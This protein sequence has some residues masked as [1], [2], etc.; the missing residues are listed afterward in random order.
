[1][2][3]A[4]LRFSPAPTGFLH[5]GSVRTALYNY[6]QARHMRGTF[7]LRIED[8]DVARSTQQST[9]Q[10]LDVL[11][12]LDMEYDE[13][14]ILQS[15]RF[16]D[17]LAAADRLL[18][19][20]HA[21]E[22]YCTSEEV[23]ARNEEAMK[24][25]RAPGYDGR[26]R[27]LT[28]DERAARVAEGRPRSVR[29][30]T[31]DEGR[32]SFTDLIRG[33]VSVE[34]TTISDF[35]IVRSNGTPVFFL[36]NAL[37]DID[38]GITHV[39]R[40]EDLIDSTHR[41]LAL[42]R[43]LGNNTPPVY[44]HMPLILGPGGGKLSKRH[45][46]VSVE[47]YRDAGYLA[48]ALINYL[49]LLG[50][51]PEDGREV[52]TRDELIAEFD[53]ERVNQS[54]AT[55]DPKKLEWMNGQ[56]IRALPL[57]DL[58]SEVLPFA[59][60]RY[61]ER[62]DIPRYEKGVALAQERAT[63]LVQIADQLEFLFTTDDDFTISDEHWEKLASTDHAAEILDLAIAHVEVSEWEHDAL[64]TITDQIRA[65]SFSMK[66]SMRVLYT[67][68]ENR[69]AGLPLFEAMLMLGRESSLRRLR[70]ARDRV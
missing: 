40:G 57:A 66:A 2:S 11:R 68:I 64:L 16:D 62:I 46:A 20:G 45:G 22:C 1:M 8:T 48:S 65:N 42:R 19:D 14:P 56:H 31:P 39:L 50:W 25:G 29:F 9:D 38:M 4:R 47:E 36:A 13:G 18:A 44:A 55:F 27:D 60:A 41:V 24:S 21:Y 23:Q 3:D 32:S 6:L 52:L 34:W 30:R 5:I 51:G 70:A 33:E 15:R 54:A 61:G 67:A 35:V 49:A 59:R 43:A 26:C 28:T 53:I 37:D 7:I 63:T 69:P 58:Q 10:I 17:Y 12:W